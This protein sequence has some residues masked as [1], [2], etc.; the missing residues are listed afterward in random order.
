MEALKEEMKNYHKEIK[1]KTYNWK[2]SINPLKI[3][4]KKINKHVKKTVQ[5]LK[6]EVIKKYKLGEF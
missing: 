4:E 3:A 6:I 5:D 1:E 2:E